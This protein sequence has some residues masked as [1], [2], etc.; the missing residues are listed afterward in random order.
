MQRLHLAHLLC[1]KFRYF[2]YVRS[3]LMLTPSLFQ[4]LFNFH[5][6]DLTIVHLL[7]DKIPTLHSETINLV[8]LCSLA[9]L[10][11]VVFGKFICQAL[12]NYFL[13]VLH[14]EEL[15]E[16]QELPILFEVARD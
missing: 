4:Q 13:K 3:S 16:V 14:H 9:D 1:T 2:S 15:S 10:Q 12:H 11:L 7:V 5:P 6:I 8:Q